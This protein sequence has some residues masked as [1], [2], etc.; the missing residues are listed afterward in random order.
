MLEKGELSIKRVILDLSL[1]FR[2]STLRKMDGKH[3]STAL[4]PNQSEI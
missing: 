3:I 2:L 1:L 4:S